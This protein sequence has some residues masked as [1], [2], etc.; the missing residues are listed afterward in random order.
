MTKSKSGRRPKP[1][2]E[3][4]VGQMA[5]E[6][7]SNRE[8]AAILGVDDKTIANRFSALLNKKRAER[9]TNIRRKQYE[10]AVRGNVSMLIWL[11]KQELEQREPKQEHEHSGEVK[12]GGRLVVEVIHVKGPDIPGNEGGNGRKVK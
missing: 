7:A 11:G 8:I 12:A 5:L 2:P 1:L 4:Q 6:G 9:R 3:D 10:M